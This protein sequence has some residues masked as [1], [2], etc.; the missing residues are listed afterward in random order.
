MEHNMENK[1]ATTQTQG[2]LTWLEEEAKQTTQTSAPFDKLPA[3]KLEE[4]KIAEIEID[5]GK[6]FQ[7]YNTENNGKAITKAIIPVKHEGISK[8]F[9]CNVKNPI[10]HELIEAGRNGQQKFKILQT[11]NRENTKYILV[12]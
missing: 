4:N 10:Y 11:G 6:P 7:K 3:M 12:K 5:F 2:D 8:N 1:N 9:W